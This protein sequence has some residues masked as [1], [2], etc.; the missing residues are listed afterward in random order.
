MASIHLY[1]DGSLPTHSRLGSSK[2][3]LDRT[4]I[5]VSRQ[6]APASVQAPFHLIA[7][8]RACRSIPTPPWPN[9][10][11]SRAFLSP[12]S[13]LPNIPPRPAVPSFHTFPDLPASLRGSNPISSHPLS[14]Q[15][16]PQPHRET[17]NRN[18]QRQTNPQR[19]ITTPYGAPQ[20]Q[21]PD[22]SMTSTKK[23]THQ[24]PP[25]KRCTAPA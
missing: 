20:P 25:A 7:C 12:I 4:F 17:N 6:D 18:D 23:S 8:P 1:G 9:A 24:P 14:T 16:D 13:R 11:F 5:A 22:S 15:P 10:R 2:S 19:P 3:S 21:T